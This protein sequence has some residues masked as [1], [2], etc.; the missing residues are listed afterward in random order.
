MTLG[1]VNAVGVVLEVMLLSSQFRI[2]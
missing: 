2:Q 1:G